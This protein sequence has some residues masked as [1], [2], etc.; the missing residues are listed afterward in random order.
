MEPR[1]TLMMIQ[2]WKD[3]RDPGS[4]SV[5][6]RWHE[7][8]ADFEPVFDILQS[9]TCPKNEGNEPAWCFYLQLK[10]ERARDMNVARKRAA[11]SG[12]MSVIRSTQFH[13]EAQK[14]ELRTLLCLAQS[15]GRREIVDYV[16]E[17]EANAPVPTP[18][19]YQHGDFG[20]LDRGEPTDPFSWR[21]ER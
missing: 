4:W 15:H 10:E 13:T 21:S 20:G 6:R 12:D 14:S 5:R 1:R 19:T 16:S 17:L 8:Q 9:E 18:P 3:E 11:V 2:C 7:M